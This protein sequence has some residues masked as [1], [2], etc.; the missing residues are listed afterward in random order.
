MEGP[1]GLDL[2]NPANLR[3]LLGQVQQILLDRL[4]PSG[5]ER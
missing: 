5:G 3:D 2:D 1:D 4:L